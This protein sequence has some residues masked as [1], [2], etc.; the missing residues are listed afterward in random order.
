MQTKWILCFAIVNLTQ[1]RIKLLKFRFQSIKL[2]SQFLYFLS[3]TI[4]YKFSIWNSAFCALAHLFVGFFRVI[5]LFLSR[6]A[7][8]VFFLFKFLLSF[9][10]KS[11]PLKIYFPTRHGDWE[12]AQFRRSRFSEFVKLVQNHL[13][14]LLNLSSSV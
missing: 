14:G 6:F 1:S 5:S 8:Y 3:N 13:N 12:I 9:V 10:Y 11:M 4:T 2:F 7:N